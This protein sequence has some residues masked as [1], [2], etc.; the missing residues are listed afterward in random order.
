LLLL[1]AFL[2]LHGAGT[3]L[4]CGAQA[5]YR[6][7]RALDRGLQ[8]LWPWGLVALGCVGSSQTRDQTRVPCIGRIL[9]H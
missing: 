4:H 8:E 5:Q 3:A 1:G 7:S 9:N 6:S 2:W